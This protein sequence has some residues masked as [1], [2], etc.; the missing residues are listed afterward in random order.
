MLR[1]FDSPQNGCA[2]RLAK[3]CQTF[4]LHQHLKAIY[5]KDAACHSFYGTALYN[6]G[7]AGTSS[8][9]RQKYAPSTRHT[10]LPVKIMGYLQRLAKT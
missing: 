4:F 6:D 2:I 7:L 8:K 3:K 1:F 9:L 5:R 10:L